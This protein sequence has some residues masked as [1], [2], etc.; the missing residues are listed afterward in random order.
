MSFEKPAVVIDSG[1]FNIK[2]G[3]ACDNHPVSMF[4]TLVGRPN[5]LKGGYGREYYDVYI[6]DEAAAEVM[7]LE[8]N[9]PVV[10]GNIENWDNMEMIWHHLF[11]RELKVAPEDRAVILACGATSTMEEKIKCCEIFFET[12]N[13]PAL[14]IQSQ[15]V[16][17]MYGSGTTT[18]ICVD[19]GYD[20]TDIVPIFEGGMVKYAHLQTGIAGFQISK[21]LKKTLEERDLLKNNLSLE[22]IEDI[23]KQY[24]YATTNC[25][26]SINKKIY[27]LPS[28]EEIDVSNETFMGAEFIFQPDLLDDNGK[29]CVSLH[30]AVITATLKCDAELRLELY[31][32]IVTCGGMATVPGINERLQMEIQD[33][34]KKSVTI[35]TSTE[36]Y[37]VAWLGGAT[38]AGLSDAKSLWIQKKQFEDYGEK[39]IKNKFM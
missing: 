38:F 35:L 19:I 18:G 23:K 9:H 30:D 5:F 34:I 21:Y 17:S 11:Y 25:A 1:S 32:A 22:V 37:A 6:G 27:K 15:P 16:L 12:L 33:N 4:R 26:M 8:V 2:A 10:R 24:L 29:K 7:D 13:C 31:N 3:F 36:P 39:I 28:G 20:T 14:C